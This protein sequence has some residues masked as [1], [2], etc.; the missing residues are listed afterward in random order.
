MKL[1]RYRDLL[2][3]QKAMEFTENVYRFTKKF[4][5]EEKF[6]L[7][8]QL[9]RSSVSIASN[10][11]EGAGRDSKKEFS[12]FLS[13]A[14]GSCFEAETQILL[15]VRVGFA[16]SEET[17]ALLGISNEIQKMIVGLKKL[18]TPLNTLPV[19]LFSFLI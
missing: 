13:I 3:W 14:M 15:A 1:N 9:N 17:T 4:P 16:V 19:F 12:Q 6:G 5:A 18:F 8:S 2:V 7:T 10:I 11:A